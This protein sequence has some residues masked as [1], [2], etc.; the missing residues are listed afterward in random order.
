MFW[1]WLELI[2]YIHLKLRLNYGLNEGERDVGRE[3]SGHFAAVD[4]DRGKVMAVG[5]VQ[6]E[7]LPAA[8]VFTFFIMCDSE[9]W[10]LFLEA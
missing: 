5:S 8:A 2:N 4:C 3:Q 10:E 1:M 7:W 9:D 6:R